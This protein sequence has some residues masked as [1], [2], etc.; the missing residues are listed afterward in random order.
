MRVLFL[1][2]HFPPDATAG[3]VRPYQFARRLPAYG[4]EPYVI[5][6]QPEFGERY[7]ASYQPVGVDPERVFRTV[8]LPSKRQRLERILGAWFP[9]AQEM[10]EQMRHRS[11]LSPREDRGALVD[12]DCDTQ[13][14]SPV[15][16]LLRFVGDWMVYPSPYA[17][18]YKPATRMAEELIPKN[19]IDAVFSTSPPRIAHL[20]AFNV[21]RRYRLPWVMDLQDPWVHKKQRSPF[22]HRRTQGLFVRCLP[23]AD[24][25][26]ANTEKYADSLRQ[27]YPNMANSIAALPNGIDESLL[28]RHW[29]SDPDEFFTVGYFGTLY[30]HQHEEVFWRGLVRWLERFPE[31]RQQVR[32]WFYG[33]IH[34]DVA[35]NAQRLAEVGRQVHVHPPVAREQVYALM[36]RCAVLLV[37]ATNHP[38]QVPSKVYEYLATNKPIIVLTETD[39]AT[40][41]LAGRFPG[42]YIV[43]GE[44][45]AAAA[46]VDLWRRYREGGLRYDR[47]D[48]LGEL[49][50]SRLTATLAEQ[51]TEVVRKR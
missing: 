5:T 11:Y 38:F 31:A 13:K 40:A 44:E 6:V 9:S 7:D 42:V 8:V 10:V 20:V 51:L 22:W 28:E 29:D 23:H 39:S 14:V 18:W 50:Y 17:G 27:Q 33:S 1:T 21:V 49:T 47:R 24:L 26:I 43:H 4:V 46:L 34:R 16:R 48:L 41:R 32:F 45:T 3:S 35:Q 2:Y 36:S 12:E 37:V 25:I 19:D 30:P 15:R